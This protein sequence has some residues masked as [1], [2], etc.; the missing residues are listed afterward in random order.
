MVQIRKDPLVNDQYYHIFSRSIAKFVVFNNFLEFNRILQLLDVYRFSDFNYKY[1]QFAEL[2]HSTQHSIMN[3][4]RNH[5]ETLI[6]VIA[7]C[8]M[9]T[10]VH[11]ILKQIAKKGIAKYIGRVLNGYSKYFNTKH[12]RT[13]PLWA[14]RFKN[15][16][17]SDDIQ[18][19]HLSRYIHLN[20]TSAGLV[21][22]P[23]N[24]QYSS[25][26]EY[27][28]KTKKSLA[29][30]KFHEVIDKNSEEYKKFVEDRKSYQRELSLIKSILIDDYNG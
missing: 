8:I 15:V 30:C 25:Y 7:Y 1:S 9:P 26:D 10:H 24:W 11:L 13:G 19:L 3:K 20:P 6:K 4:I 5:D 18:L 28:N 29:I 16:L 27:I 12:K 22:K 23:E 17:I 21:V 2:R 14:G